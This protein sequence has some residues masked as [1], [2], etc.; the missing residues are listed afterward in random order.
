MAQLSSARLAFLP[1]L[2]F[3][4]TT[5]LPRTT[6]CWQS[7]GF[8][9]LLLMPAFLESPASPPS[10]RKRRAG[11]WQPG[12]PE[13][14]RGAQQPLRPF[15]WQGEGAAGSA[16]GACLLFAKDKSAHASTGGG[17]EREASST[18][19]PTPPASRLLRLQPLRARLRAAPG[20]GGRT[21][22]RAGATAGAEPPS[23]RQK[24]QAASPG[25]GDRGFVPIRRGAGALE[26]RPVPNWTRRLQRRE[27]LKAALS[28]VLNRAPSPAAVVARAPMAL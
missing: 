6:C 11:D 13:F 12:A 25:E 8:H 23:R 17:G 15:G 20:V 1:N 22:R 24:S 7:N 9:S 26:K 21:G 16:E 10:W 5:L 27:S 4:P 18:P 14:A 2:F 19:Y 3:L 28:V